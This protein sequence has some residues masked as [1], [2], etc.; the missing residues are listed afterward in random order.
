MMINA[1]LWLHWIFPKISITIHSF[2]KF[3]SNLE[4]RICIGVEMCA[5]Q[6]NFVLHR[7]HKCSWS[8]FNSTIYSWVPVI[9]NYISCLSKYLLKSGYS[10][11]PTVS[12][13]TL[14]R[15]RRK[16]FCYLLNNINHKRVPKQK[17][18]YHIFFFKTKDGNKGVQWSFH[19]CTFWSKSTRFSY[20]W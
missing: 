11:L 19:F 7:S 10:W 2:E 15:S 5:W 1:K 20:L 9:Q 17:R 4:A 3:K 12:Q 16:K 13:V 14:G 6:K 18:E 8:K